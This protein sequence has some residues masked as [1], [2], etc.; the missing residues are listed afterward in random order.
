MSKIEWARSAVNDVKSVRDYIA[1]DSEAYAE[2]FVQKIV[3]A[4]EKAGAFPRVGR[5]VREA[6]AD[7]IREIVFGNYRIIY[8]DEEA[9]V[10]VLMVIHGA[11]DLTQVSPKPWEAG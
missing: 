7:D 2:R 4:V 5:R 6:D 8:R 9:R 10:L 11:R 1:R 3:E